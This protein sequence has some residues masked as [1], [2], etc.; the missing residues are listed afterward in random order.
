MNAVDTNVFVYGLDA[1]ESAKQA[2]AQALLARLVRPP[3]ETVLPW[4]VA[5]ELL[6]CLRKWESAGRITAADVEAHFRDALVLFPL[7]IP[8]AKVFQVAFD[9]HKRFSLSHWD[10]MLLAAC[11]EA[12][13]TTLFSEDL[14]A[15]TDYDGVKVVNPFV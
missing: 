9:L 2:K 6:S 3:V 10:S 12:G 13:V 14:G 4:Q 1:T 11:K 15:G 7:S 5:G 8:T